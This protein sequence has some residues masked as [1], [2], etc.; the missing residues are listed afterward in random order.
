[1]ISSLAPHYPKTVPG[2]KKD[3]TVLYVF[4]GDNDLK[5]N[6]SHQM[7]SLAKNGTPE[8]SYVAAFCARG[9]LEWAPGNIGR[10]LHHTLSNLGRK[11]EVVV[12]S[13][14]EGNRVFVLGQEKHLPEALT[15]PVGEVSQAATI[16]DFLEWGIRSF[17]SNHVAVIF[18]SHGDGHHGI[19]MDGKGKEMSLPELRQTLEA[20]KAAHGK[21]LDLVGFESCNMSQ[22]EV[23][24]ELHEVADAMVASPS[25]LYGTPWN[26]PIAL[27]S[28][29]KADGGLAAAR[30]MVENAKTKFGE[31]TPTVSALDLEKMP[32]LRNSLDEFSKD[33]LKGD[34]SE[35]TLERL[36]YNARSYGRAQAGYTKPQR[37]LIDLYGFCQE[38]LKNPQVP[39][40]AA[41]ES[42]KRV[43]GTLKE[44]VPSFMDRQANLGEGHGISI[45]APTMRGLLKPL[46][47]LYPQLKMSLEGDWDDFIA[48]RA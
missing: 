34:I 47:K 45:F 1:M 15:A 10:K 38:L 39:D 28:I 11:K 43:Q 9:D 41:R 24:Y 13:A 4:N 35:S 5:E 23:A 46:G 44:L 40:C 3:W 14:W 29:L 42:A 25:V 32:Q 12:P 27:E 30:N 7:M 2:T 31:G 6:T 48:K 17:P 18:S 19:L 36:I 21:D 37:E 8:D 33:L 20:A 22:V 26:H 16:S